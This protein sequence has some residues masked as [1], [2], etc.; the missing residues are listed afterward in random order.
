MHKHC[1]VQAFDKITKNVVSLSSV[2]I[3]FESTYIGLYRSS[4][5]YKETNLTF[6][7]YPR[8]KEIMLYADD[9]FV[10]MEVFFVC[11]FFLD[12]V[13]ATLSS[14]NAQNMLIKKLGECC[15]S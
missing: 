15:N 14:L 4:R 3:S 6:L 5:K 10:S 13:R 7:L 8:M 11:F 9:S 2:Q 12:Y 1:T